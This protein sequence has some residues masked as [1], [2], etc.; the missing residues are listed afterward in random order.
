[1]G[2]GTV[3]AAW[4]LTAMV[5][6][7]TG[8]AGVESAAETGEGVA[9]DGAASNRRRTPQLRGAMTRALTLAH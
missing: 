4:E 7:V 2:L 6:V 5:A 8:R 9:V 3:V 1:M